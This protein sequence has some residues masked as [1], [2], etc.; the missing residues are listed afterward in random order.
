MN[1]LKPFLVDLIKQFK[2]GDQD[3]TRYCIDFFHRES[4]GIW[5]GRARAKIARNLQSVRISNS[6]S[7]RLLKTILGRLL[8]GNFSEQFKD[9]LDLALRISPNSTLEAAQKGLESAKDYVRRYCRWA[10]ER[11][12]RQMENRAVE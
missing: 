9:Q 2:E 5:H 6:D 8:T 3:A 10:I 4:K 1:E 12:R 7:E 11:H